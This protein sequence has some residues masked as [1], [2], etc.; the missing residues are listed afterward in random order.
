MQ[1]PVLNWKCTM[2]PDRVLIINDKLDR[3]RNGAVLLHFVILFSYFPV[4]TEEK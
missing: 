2:Q 4:D 3:M 1:W